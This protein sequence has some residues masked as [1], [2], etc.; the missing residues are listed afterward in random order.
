[1][2]DDDPGLMTIFAEALERTDPAAPGRLP[3]PRL[4][5]RR[6]PA[7]AGRGAARRPRRGRPVPRTRRT[8]IPA[9]RHPNP[10]NRPRPPTRNTSAVATATGQT[11]PRRHHRRPYAGRP[12]ERSAGPVIAGRYTLLEVDRRRGDGYGLPRRADR[13]GQAAGRGQ[14]DQGG[15]DSRQ[16]L[17]RF[18]A[19]RQALALMDH[20]NIARVSTAARTDGRP[21]V[22]RHGAGQGR[23]DH[24]VLRPPAA[25]RSAAAAGAVRARLPGGPARPPEGDHPPRHQA[26]QR[27]G[28]RCATAG[29]CRR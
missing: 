3:G 12:D 20:P 16:V 29:P 2:P 8:G 21:A 10:R 22:L 13:A 14:A 4:R 19:E 24:R 23:A 26:E 6:R 18:D 9:R 15:M 1:M 28:R 27:A 17:A 11:G 7:R 5:G 25:T